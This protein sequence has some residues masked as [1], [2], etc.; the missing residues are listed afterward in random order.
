[1]LFALQQHDEIE[2][3]MCMHK[4]FEK[5]KAKTVHSEIRNAK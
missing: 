4:T 3:A 1:M 5:T 2:L